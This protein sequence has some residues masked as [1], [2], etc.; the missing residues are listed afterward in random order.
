MIKTEGRGR[1]YSSIADTIG[2][3]PLVE[4]AKLAAT[5]GAKARILA[6]L[7]FF[8]PLASVKD[9][10]GVAMIDALEAAGKLLED[11]AKFPRGMK[12]WCDEVHSAFSG[13]KCGIYTMT[14]LSE[15]RSAAHPA[16]PKE[17]PEDRAPDR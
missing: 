7:E 8:N 2:D 1:I 4:M 14:C 3:T 9:R 6:K 11:P 13:A 5:H 16:P 15:G 10:I 12:A 17:G